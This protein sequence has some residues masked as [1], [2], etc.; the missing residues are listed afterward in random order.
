MTGNAMLTLKFDADNKE[1]IAN[2]SN[3]P[4]IISNDKFI[5]VEEIVKQVST[6]GVGDIVSVS[7]VEA[8]DEA[9]EEMIKLTKEH[10]KEDAVM[11]QCFD[12]DD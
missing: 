5:L 3:T 4:I 6:M 8:P 9:T 1:M 2:F 12:F 7:L 11:E 10:Q